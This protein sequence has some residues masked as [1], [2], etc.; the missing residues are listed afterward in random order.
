ME[1]KCALTMTN[2]NGFPM[3]DGER[4]MA[5]G[6][7][8]R[9]ADMTFS[10]PTQEEAAHETESLIDHLFRCTERAAARGKQAAVLLSISV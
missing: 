5:S 7:N 4:L 3:I 9:T 8:L 1:L 10:S 6:T 2:H